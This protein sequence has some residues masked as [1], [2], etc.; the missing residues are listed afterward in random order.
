MQNSSLIST[1]FTSRKTIIE[2][3]Q[4]QGYNV[5][6]H[7]SFSITEINHM[8]NSRQLDMLIE[9]NDHSSKIYINYLLEQPTVK[10]VDLIIADLFT[11]T[12]TLTKNDTLMLISTDD[13]NDTLVDKL[14][15]IWATEGYFVIIQNIKRLQFNI[16]KHSLVPPHRI[17][18][19]EEVEQIKRRY[20]IK[21]NSQFPEISRFEP[22]AQAIGIRPGQ[23]C[24]ILRNSKTSIISIYYRICVQ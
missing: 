19:D 14:K 23:V 13:A 22:V 18:S 7:M 10:L 3:M 2:I 1:I 12:S 11:D 20:N 4:T 17:L 6:D 24:E 15:Y 9:K 8:Y 16:I 5:E 21:D